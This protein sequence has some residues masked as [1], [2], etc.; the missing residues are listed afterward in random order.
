VANEWWKNTLIN[1]ITVLPI[2]V[3]GNTIHPCFMVGGGLCT[4]NI[5]PHDS[6]KEKRVVLPSKNR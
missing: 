1:G 5:T 2:V 6:V 3:Y 4:T